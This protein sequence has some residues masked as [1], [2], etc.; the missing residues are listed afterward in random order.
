[1]WGVNKKWRRSLSF[2]ITQS[3]EGKKTRLGYLA[4]EAKKNSTALL[5][6]ACRQVELSSLC[7]LGLR[8]FFTFSMLPSEWGE[9]C[10]SH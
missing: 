7:T 6:T 3:Q 10:K 2:L 1:M 4:S 5:P 8:M 9:D